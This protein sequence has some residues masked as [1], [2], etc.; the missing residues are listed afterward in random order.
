MWPYRSNPT[1]G[2][3]SAATTETAG[4][5][6]DAPA[7]MLKLSPALRAPYA[8]RRLPGLLGGF[9]PGGSGKG[10]PR[11]TGARRIHG[12]IAERMK[13]IAEDRGRRRLTAR[14]RRV[15]EAVAWEGAWPATRAALSRGLRPRGG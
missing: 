14:V 5:R 12:T 3:D 11:G 6:G 4:W 10:G 1:K 15:M 8:G 2:K 7:V 9:R 13:Q